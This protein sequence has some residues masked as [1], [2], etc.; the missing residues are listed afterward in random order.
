MPDDSTICQNNS[1][2]YIGGN[3]V[4]DTEIS[5]SNKEQISIL[6]TNDSTEGSVVNCS[7]DT[8]HF[9]LTFS[10]QVHVHGIEFIG[11][12]GRII[13]MVEQASTNSSKSITVG[14]ALTVTNT[15]LLCDIC[16]FDGNTA[17]IGGAIFSER[18]SNVTVRNS[19]FTSNHAQGCHS[20]LCFGGVIYADATHD[21]TITI[22]NCSFQNNTS[23]ECGGAV[24]VTKSSHVSYNV[25]KSTSWGDLSL[26][27]QM[28]TFINN[29]AKIGGGI[30]LYNSNAVMFNSSFQHNGARAIGGSIV[31]NASSVVV[32]HSLALIAPPSIPALLSVN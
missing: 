10:H 15:T 18:G 16:G 2:S 5:L 27:I 8:A 28:S 7:T 13:R 26:S 11:C 23:A 19:V 17:N 32:L 24:V 30:Y 1:A 6:S 14:G 21:T 9:S 22:Q 31:S 3:H 25:C 20:S 4:L 29:R 12:D